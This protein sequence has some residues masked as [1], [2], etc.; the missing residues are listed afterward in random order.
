MDTDF[1]EYDLDVD[2]EEYNPV[3]WSV[4]S[5]ASMVQG[6]I[7]LFVTGLG[8]YMLATSLD[9]S[10]T[11]GV[12]VLT[13]VCVMAAAVYAFRLM[14]QLRVG[15][16][17]AMTLLSV[18]CEVGGALVLWGADLNRQFE[19]FV[20]VG[21][22]Q[23]VSLVVAA[24]AVVWIVVTRRRALRA[25]AAERVMVQRLTRVTATDVSTVGSAPKKVQL[26]KTVLAARRVFKGFKRHHAAVLRT[27]KVEVE[28]WHELAVER[29]VLRA[30]VYCLLTITI[31][32]LAYF[33]VIFGVKVTK[34]QN[35]QWMIA[36]VVSL[37]TDFLVIEP[38]IELLRTLFAL[39]VAAMTRDVRNVIYDSLKIDATPSV[40]K[41]LGNV[42]PLA[43]GGGRGGEGG[44]GGHDDD[45]DDDAESHVT[46]RLVDLPEPGEVVDGGEHVVDDVGGEE[47]KEGEVDDE[48]GGG[49]EVEAVCPS[50]RRDDPVVEPLSP[51][52]GTVVNPMAEVVED[53]AVVEVQAGEV[54]VETARSGTSGGPPGNIRASRGESLPGA[55]PCDEE[56]GFGLF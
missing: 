7:G 31:I 2:D 22:I 40:A 27:R 56:D 37:L 3:M 54:V 36:T 34:D 18:G 6:W 42:N 17:G 20:I 45:D 14:R 43:E 10:A 55:M 4:M 13:G 9:R 41:E 28:S 48:V 19:V 51:D 46:P 12:M 26:V 52:V 33:N 49:D 39:L 1:S 53:T 24:V 21:A 5:V 23:G 15:A 25:V 50:P 29:T 30:L 11:I 38:L 8:L 16:S 44:E 35:V 47:V 32:V